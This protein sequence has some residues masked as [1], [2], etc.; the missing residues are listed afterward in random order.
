MLSYV[1]N[2]IVLARN[3][4]NNKKNDMQIYYKYILVDSDFPIFNQL[5]IVTGIPIFN[6]TCIL[7]AK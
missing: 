1:S 2:E 4:L 6:H 7:Q 3:Q 5:L